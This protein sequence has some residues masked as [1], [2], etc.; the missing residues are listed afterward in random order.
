M[1]IEDAIAHAAEALRDSA[2]EHKRLGRA[3]RRQ[4]RLCMEKLAEL[5]DA[6]G[7][8]G[9]HFILEGEEEETTHGRNTHP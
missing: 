5:R 7:S 6:C 9:I 4:A 1:T 2:R 3:H 8:L